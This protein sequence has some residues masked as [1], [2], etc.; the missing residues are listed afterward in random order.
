MT[1]KSRSLTAVHSIN[2]TVM[3]S[4]PRRMMSNK[5][6]LNKN[7]IKYLDLTISMISGRNTFIIRKWSHLKIRIELKT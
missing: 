4:N 3:R 7:Q 1:I 6:Y 5:D 2:N